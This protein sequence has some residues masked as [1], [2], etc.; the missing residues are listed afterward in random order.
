MTISA[1]VISLSASDLARLVEALD[2]YEYWQLGH[3]FPRNEGLVFIPGDYLGP[4]DDRYWRDRTPTA[5]QRE[6][7]QQVIACRQLSERLR[8]AAAPQ[9]GAD[10]T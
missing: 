4:G 8:R 7:I 9:A 10:P 3:E 5:V 2:A 1:A 6:T